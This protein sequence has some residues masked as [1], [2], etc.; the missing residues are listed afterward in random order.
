[1]SFVHV[2]LEVYCGYEYRKDNSEVNMRRVW[3]SFYGL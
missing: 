1:M 3:R 2:L